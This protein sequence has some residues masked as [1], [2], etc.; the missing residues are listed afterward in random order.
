MRA[1][2]GLAA[3]VVGSRAASVSWGP[4]CSQETT[5][6]GTAFPRCLDSGADKVGSPCTLDYKFNETS[7]CSCGVEACVPLNGT[8]STSK[9]QYLVIGDSISLGY[10]DSLTSS[11][12]SEYEVVHAPGNCDNVNW[13]VMCLSGWLG[14]NPARWDVVSVNHGLHDLAFPD[15]EHLALPIYTQL[16][17]KEVALLRALLKPSAKL[18]WMRTTPV[19]TNPPPECVLIPG[20]VQTDV[21]AYNSA[22]DFVMQLRGVPT[23]DLEAVINEFCGAGYSNCT[24]AQCGGPHYTTQGFTMLGDAAAKCVQAL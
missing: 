11:L 19:P 1:I 15:N 3:L 6:F 17:V 21:Q 2:C 8:N 13:G 4:A 5:C 22:A 14:A 24:I 23:C 10:L 7:L 20:R 16:L 9:P 18:L 12:S